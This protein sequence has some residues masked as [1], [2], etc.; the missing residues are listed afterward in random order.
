MKRVL[1]TATG[2]I[3]LLSAYSQDWIMQQTNKTADLSSGI[4]VKRILIVL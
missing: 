1:Y 2:I 3:T 4:G